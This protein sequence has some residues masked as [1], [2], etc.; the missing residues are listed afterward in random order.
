MLF[1]KGTIHSPIEEFFWKQGFQRIAGVDEAGR[2]AIAGPLFVGL[3]I[4]PKDYKNPLIKDSKLLSPA[5][6]E[7]LFEVI[8]QDA[9]EYAIAMASLEE[10]NELGI[11]RALFL[12]IK[13]CLMQI[14]E[15]DL[16]LV[17]GPIQVPDFKGIQKAII[18]GD[19]LSLSIAGGSIL[20]KVSRDRFMEEIAKRYP[21]FGFEKHKGYATKEH[22]E[23]IKRYGASPL[24][25]HN[26]KC[27]KQAI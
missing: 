18:K 8:C 11:I 10:I 3:V 4:F 21:E 17:D 27:F 2:G 15:T 26:F 25:R 6:R 7:K 12:A 20:A 14:T 1:P 19:K 16:L 9:I 5:K 22:L 23:A 24:H 13:R